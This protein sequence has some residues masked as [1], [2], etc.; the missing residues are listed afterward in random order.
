MDRR[1]FLGAL[2]FLAAPLAAEAQQASKVYRVGWVGLGPL[3]AFSDPTNM[4]VRAFRV[5]LRDR[6][7]VEGQNLIL[8]LRSV[9]GKIERASAVMADL[10]RLGVGVILAASP[11]LVRE[12]TR[13]TTAVPIVM[14][15]RAPVEEGLVASLA[16]PGGNVTGITRD[17][18]PDMESKRLDLLKQG[19]PTLRRVAYLGL[20]AEWEGPGGR[21]LRSAAGASG[22]TTLFLAE[23][24]ANDYTK[25]F[26]LIVRKRAQ[27]IIVSQTLFHTAHRR[28]IADFAA[29]HKLPSV[30]GYREFVEV[31]A[32]MSYGSDNADIYRRLAI[33]VDKILKGAKPADLPVEQPTKFELVINLKTAKALGLTIPPSLLQ[34][35]DEIIQ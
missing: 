30:A 15:S 32:L 5:E 24:G 28:L 13:V 29:T 31:G 3:R 7:Y 26:D 19:I 11:E 2:G 35:A 8:E 20:K 22:V 9:D 27:A 34:R 6:G 25:A 33:Y 17:T 12:A 21:N 10:V 1:A 23:R 18:G 4:A 14:F 16:R